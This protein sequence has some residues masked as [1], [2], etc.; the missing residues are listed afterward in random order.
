MFDAS[1]QTLRLQSRDDPERTYPDATC[2]LEHEGAFQLLVS[3]ILSAQCTDER[4][5]MVTPDLFRRYPTP[6]KMAAAKQEDIEHIIQ[7]TGFFRAK[8]RIFGKRVAKLLSCMAAKCHAIWMPSC[9]FRA[10]VVK[11]PT[12]FWERL[13]EFLQAWSSIRTS[14]DSPSDWD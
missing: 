7:S 6:A 13:L 11:P 5:N 2:A 4:V 1:R 14:R 8:A 10:S 12:S 9:S 3:T